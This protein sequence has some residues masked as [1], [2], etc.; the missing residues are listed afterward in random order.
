MEELRKTKENMEDFLNLSKTRIQS[1]E[2]HYADLGIEFLK[3]QVR[4]V[5]V[6]QHDGMLS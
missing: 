6:H 1:K 3:N 5:G 4:F 2:Q